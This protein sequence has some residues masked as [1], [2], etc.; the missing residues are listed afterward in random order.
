M[1]PYAR[2]GIVL[3]AFGL[4]ALA[5]PARAAAQQ[6]DRCRVLCMPELK[7]EPTLTVENL[8]SRPVIETLDGSGR[9]VESARAGRD[10]VFE[11]I[12]ALDVP[13]EIPRL[14]LTLEAIFVPFGETDEHPFT[15]VPA[16]ALRSGSIRD[17]GVEIESELNFE[18]FDTD[19]TGGWVSSH[20]DIVDKFSPAEEPRAESVYTH[21][22]NF[23]WD[24]AFHVFNRLPD[25][26]WLRNVEAEVSLDYVATGL[27]NA[28]DVLGSERFVTR[29]SPWSISF[30]LVMPLAPLVP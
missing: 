15:G 26:S 14:G 10:R 20:V 30:V 11:L 3:A 18:L 21:K 4:A 7:I 19:Q 23:E 25:G 2:A 16:S 5:A 29:A 17:N 27:P 9:V 24:T 6:A 8:W 12:L 13:T 28:G 1:T 22:L